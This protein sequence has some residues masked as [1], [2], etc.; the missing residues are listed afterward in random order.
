MVTSETVPFA[1]TG[2]LAEVV[3]ELSLQLKSLGYDIRIFMP[4][5]YH[6]DRASLK[7]RD[8]AL[9]IWLGKGEEWAAVYEGTLPDSD[10]P[11]YF[12]DHERFFGRDGIYGHRPDEGFLDNAARFALLSRGCF[13]LCRMLHWIPDVLHCHDW[14]AAPAC[15]LLKKEEQYR[16]FSG[17]KSVLTI[18]NLGYQGVF[19]LS[20]AIYIQPETDHISLS[21]LEF[22]GAL[23]FLKSG[24]MTADKITTV[25]PFYAEEIKS[26][27]QG[28]GL[29][30]LLNYRREDLKG[31]LNGIDY[32]IWNP[33]LDTVIAP[34]NFSESNI[35]NK[36]AVK[37]RLQ[38]EMGLTVDT[39]IPVVGL[40]S[41]LVEQK[42]VG[43][44]CGPGYGALYSIC[45]DFNVQFIIL[46]TGE[47]WCED[48]LNKLS[49]ELPNLVFWSGYNSDLAHL[50][51]AGSD[52]FLM[53]S[54]YEPCG[55]NQMYSLAYGTLPIVR[56]TG[57]LA[58]TVE[59]YDQQQASGTGF[60]FYD[61][62][63]EVLYNVL[64]WVVDTWEN[65]KPHINKMRKRAMKER[66][67]WEQSAL[68]YVKVY[69]E[70]SE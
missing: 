31:I 63:P 65:R 37:K 30:G 11:V 61:M 33:E 7:K 36:A 4:R 66:F 17:T 23:N 39:Q 69:S 28:F 59:N 12:L 1:K 43:E 3:T 40:I 53:P 20:D 50:I 68:E 60:V 8:E 21:T 35:K 54:K 32:S 49:S 45:Y 22:N 34:D 15:Y 13:Q 14:T 62:Y 67:T 52:F 42:G 55:L 16:E 27:E 44:L 9:G 6:I 24:I 19:A 48:E 57:G 2:G 56:H 10:I 5:Y 51:E 18:H 47:K 58:D 38:K 64:D 70:D 26:P 41:R 46:G 29:D 25:S